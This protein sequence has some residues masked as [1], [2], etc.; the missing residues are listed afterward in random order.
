MILFQA[1]ES[2]I[3]L[4]PDRGYEPPDQLQNVVLP[5]NLPER[6]GP[7]TLNTT[8]DAM[9]AYAPEQFE[10]PRLTDFAYLV[11]RQQPIDDSFTVDPRAVQVIPGL[12][13]I[14]LNFMM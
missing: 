1:C 11:L 4:I 9:T 10:V 2:R 5:F 14:I 6:V 8:L 13:I 12:T 7:E 3:S